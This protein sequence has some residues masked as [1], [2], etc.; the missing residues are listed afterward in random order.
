[1]DEVPLNKL[2][3]VYLKIRAAEQALQQEYDEKLESLAAQKKEVQ[4]AMREKLL[5]EK[6]TSIK[7]DAGLVLLTTETR[8]WTSDWDSFYAFIRKHDIPQLLER[9]VAQGNMRKFLEDNPDNKPPGLN[10][11]T[12]Y[13]VSV[14]KIK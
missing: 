3:K 7:T 2:A 13:K 5:A 10:A 14:R 4:S 1:M 6:A 11:D 9:R 8:Y 12:E